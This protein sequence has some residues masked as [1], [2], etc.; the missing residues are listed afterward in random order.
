[1]LSDTAYLPF[2]GLPQALRLPGFG[3]LSAPALRLLAFG[4]SLTL[5]P[6][7]PH[8]D[9]RFEPPSPF[10]PY[11]LATAEM[12]GT[13]SAQVWRVAAI[14]NGLCG[15]TARE[16]V[17]QMD[18]VRTHDNLGRHGCGLRQMLRHED[19]DVA[20]IMMGTNDLPGSRRAEEIASD[21]QLLHAACHAAGLPTVVLA[22][23]TIRSGS[24]SAEDVLLDEKRCR[25]NGLLGRWAAVTPRA[26]FLDTCCFVRPGVDPS[27]F[28]PDGVHFAS[29]GSRALGLGVAA[30]LRM[31]LVGGAITIR[32]GCFQHVDRLSA[33]DDGYE[34]VD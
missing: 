14:A 2:S 23:P 19:F 17:A 24:A 15:V 7:L 31:L 34:I 26:T 22:A 5:A 32:S 29:E 16:A 12:L 8:H 3:P 11:A 30:H 33:E 27:H 18:E 9:A 25:V 21:I 10:E 28:E 1:M 13:G 6:I 4:D 20:S